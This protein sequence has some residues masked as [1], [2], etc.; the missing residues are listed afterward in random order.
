MRYKRE[1]ANEEWIKAELEARLDPETIE[2]WWQD[3]GEVHG[4]NENEH[5]TI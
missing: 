4:L 1:T 2:G 3:F 5:M